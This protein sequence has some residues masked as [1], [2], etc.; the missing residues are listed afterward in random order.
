MKTE[1]VD[2]KYDIGDSFTIR[3]EGFLDDNGTPAYKTTFGALRE[4]DLET[5]DMVP[6][7]N[8]GEVIL[9]EVRQNDPDYRKVER[10]DNWLDAYREMFEKITEGKSSEEV[11]QEMKESLIRF[12]QYSASVVREEG[13]FFYYIIKLF[14]DIIEVEG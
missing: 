8:S 14:D 2:Y 10:F 7:K 1:G 6:E 9:L 5:L 3:I 4:S 11:E 12:A 13:R